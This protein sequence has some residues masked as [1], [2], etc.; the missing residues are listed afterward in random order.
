MSNKRKEKEEKAVRMVTR[1]IIGCVAT[2]ILGGIL[3]ELKLSAL[4]TVM[5]V[6]SVVMVIV[7]FLCCMMYLDEQK[8]EKVRN[9]G[10]PY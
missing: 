10:K 8:K 4:G 9:N 7:T 1:A 2:A 3:L 6:L 5:V